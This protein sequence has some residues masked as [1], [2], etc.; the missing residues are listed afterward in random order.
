[1]CPSL[2]QKQNEDL[3]ILST[4]YQFF[5]FFSILYQILQLTG[6]KAGEQR[7]QSHP[8]C[9]F[10][11][12]F[13]SG[14][15]TTKPSTSMTL[16]KVTPWGATLSDGSWWYSQL[17][18]NKKRNMKNKWPISRKMTLCIRCTPVKEWNT[19]ETSVTL[20]YLLL[21]LE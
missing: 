7:R 2:S 14:S 1:M 21:R 18:L 20:V 5:I 19:S 12:H 4:I 13:Y 10:R 3:P 17:H 11:L 9:L 16:M 15:E 6:T 8:E